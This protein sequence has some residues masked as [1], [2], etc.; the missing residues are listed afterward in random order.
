MNNSYEKS[1]PSSRYRVAKHLIE[2]MREHCD[3]VRKVPKEGFGSCLPAET[4]VSDPQNDKKVTQERFKERL[5]GTGKERNMRKKDVDETG[6]NFFV[7]LTTLDGR[8]HCLLVKKAL[9][10]V[11]R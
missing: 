7:S 2:L 1:F 4:S 5:A 3:N 6:S 10:P 8:C 11:R 9:F